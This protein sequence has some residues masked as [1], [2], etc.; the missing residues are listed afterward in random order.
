MVES[1]DHLC[2]EGTQHKKNSTNGESHFE[3][4]QNAQIQCSS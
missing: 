3:S 2:H 1:Y 4:Q